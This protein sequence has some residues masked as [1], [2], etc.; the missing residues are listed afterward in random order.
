MFDRTAFFDNVRAS[1]FNGKMDQGQVDG[2]EAIL[3]AFETYVPHWDVRW[4]GYMMSTTYHETS[5]TMQPIEE[6]G[7]GEGQPYG[8]IDPE[9]GQGYWGRGFVQLTWRDNYRRA[10]VECGWEDDNSC[11]W[12]AEEALVPGKAARIMFAG[13]SQGWFRSD[14]QGRQTL[15]RYFNIATDDAFM[16]R[17]I[18]NGDKNK[19]PG[20]S[21]GVSI[22]HLI[23]DYHVKFLAALRASMTS[24]G[25]TPPKP[26]P[27]PVVRVDIFQPEGV[28]IV[29]TVNG[30]PWEEYEP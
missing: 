23:E 1:L 4:L 15:D 30:R 26:E 14:A 28:D 20:W 6:Y 24:G 19:V 16:A 13:M 25:E 3:T 29:V 8:E 10:D 21:D 9:T 12:H 17:E 18:I 27:Y 5:A 11:E 22:G 7:R 2:M